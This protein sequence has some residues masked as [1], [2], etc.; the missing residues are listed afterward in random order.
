MVEIVLLLVA[1]MFFHVGWSARSAKA[2]KKESEI[3]WRASERA[4]VHAYYIIYGEEPKLRQAK[5][6][7]F[8]DRLTPFR[9]GGVAPLS[10]I[11][12]GKREEV[13]DEWK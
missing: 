4:G 9:Q 1:G 12:E 7:V 13:T 5:N 3:Y 6:H 2:E 11:H 10:T 8:Q